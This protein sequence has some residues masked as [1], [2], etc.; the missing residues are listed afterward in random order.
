MT[1]NHIVNDE[2]VL[3]FRTVKSFT[4]D[5][6]FTAEDFVMNWTLGDYGMVFEMGHG[7]GYGLYFDDY[8]AIETEQISYFPEIAKRPLHF[9]GVCLNG[10]FDDNYIDDF[11]TPTGRTYCEEMLYSQGGASAVFSATRDSYGTPLY[12]YDGIVLY[13]DGETYIANMGYQLMRSLNMRP[14]SIGELWLNTVS[15]YIADNDMTD[16]LNIYTLLQFAGFSCSGAPLPYITLSPMT[17]EL[18]TIIP[19]DMTSFN[20]FG[21]FR[22]SPYD[23]IRFTPSN[24]STGFYCGISHVSSGGLR[25]ESRNLSA[26]A[27]Y[28]ITVMPHSEFLRLDI[29]DNSEKEIRLYFYTSGSDRYIDGDTLDWCGIRP[30]SQSTSIDTTDKA[31]RLKS[32][33]VTNADVN[34]YFMYPVSGVY[35]TS[36]MF[37]IAIDCQG[38]GFIGTPLL[39]VDAWGN[40]TTFE[41]HGVDRLFATF[42][43][44]YSSWGWGSQRHEF[45]TW[46]GSSFSSGSPTLFEQGGDFA[47]KRNE[48]E[49]TAIVEARIPKRAL[50]NAD[51]IRFVLYSIPLDFSGVE[52]YGAFMSLPEDPMLPL[53][54][55]TSWTTIHNLAEYRFGEAIFENYTIDKPQNMSIEIYPNPVNGYALISSKDAESFT[56]FDINGKILKEMKADKASITVNTEEL[57]TG[58]VIVRANLKKERRVSRFL[59]V[60]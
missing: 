37:I 39:S 19:D 4:T 32:I 25:E 58:I 2:L 53:S 26:G 10:I 16:E 1:I 15:N 21:L 34:Y 30:I 18:S 41:T 27:P 9:A 56:L 36:R 38:G 49:N 3:G 14:Q 29:R 60:K 12:Y 7:S 11:E 13:V 5:R 17:T 47:I 50:N 54:Y 43:W 59:V 33:S 31:L 46:E 8:T 23:I 42:F 44:A 22:R 24:T 52:K 57:P 40:R 35:D 51:T 20:G 6:G 28:T 55:T 48:E 45:R